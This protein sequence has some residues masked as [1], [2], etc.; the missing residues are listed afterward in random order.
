MATNK[1]SQQRSIKQEI[2]FRTN[3]VYFCAV[4]IALAVIVRLV[5]IQYFSPTFAMYSERLSQRIITTKSLKAVRGEIMM[6]DGEPLATALTLYQ[7]KFDFGS[8]ALDSTEQYSYLSDSLAGRL[9]RYFADEGYGKA[10]FKK[11]LN[12]YY[13]YRRGKGLR[14][15]MLLP[16][17][18]DYSEWCELKEY[19]LLNWDVGMCYERIDTNMRVYPLG[20]IAKRTVGKRVSD[21]IKTPFGIEH[22]FD[23]ILRGEDGVQIRQRVA[24]GYTANVAKNDTIPNRPKIDG[25]DIVTT[26][27]RRIQEIADV[28]LRK[29]MVANNAIWG[30]AIV[31]SVETG[32]ILALSNLSEVSSGVYAE[33]ESNAFKRM[34]PGSTFK[35]ASLLA[36]VEDKGIDINSSIPIHEGQETTAKKDERIPIGNTKAQGIRDDHAFSDTMSMK[37][38]VAHSSNIFFA[39]AIYQS[40]KDD[41]KRYVDFLRKLHLDRP[42][43]LELFGEQAPLFNDYPEKEAKDAASRALRQ[44]WFH[45]NRL[46]QI[47]Y[48]YENELTPIQTATLYNAVANNGRMVAPMLIRELRHNGR[49]V[50][51][52]EPRVLNERICST[53]SLDKVQECL[54]EVALTGTAR[55]YFVR[56]TA[57][58]RVAAKTGTAYD[59]MTKQY[60]GSMVAYFPTDAPK[61]TVMVAV[62][63]T[64]SRGQYYGAGVSGP[65]VRDIIYSLYTMESEWRN[66]ITDNPAIERPTQI[67]GGSTEQMRKVAS[68]LDMSFSTDKRRGWSQAQVDDSTGR[69]EIKELTVEQ[70]RM[71]RV[72]GMGLKDAL[73]LLESRGLK[74]GV[75]GHGR[76]ASQSIAAGATIRRGDYVQIVLK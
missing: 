58:F 40:Y 70:G 14:T 62:K 47:A 2:R 74:V 1:D 18:V 37:Y 30:T 64:P 6:R 53:A 16:R 27:D 59:L 21:R 36:L 71:P 67:K 29:N 46:C 52:Y 7:V 25:A 22:V 42:M 76:V 44:T 31:M 8:E 55:Q 5:Y 12:R 41:P 23:S 61:Y 43:G 54:E 19:T 38:C 32:E 35:L 63:N 28:A 3:I 39:N 11:V 73:F 72:V 60:L 68:T 69:A 49:I 50:E 17:P 65:V 10:H 51:S 66:K 26:L 45:N 9:G 33:I 48:G 20:D 57:L 4:M 15:V 13:D 75:T 56:D 34:C 24:H